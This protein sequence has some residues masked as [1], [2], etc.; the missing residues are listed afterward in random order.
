[1]DLQKLRL[2]AI[3]DVKKKLKE[4]VKQDWLIIQASA[5]LDEL[6][7]A[8]N[9]LV[10]RLREWYELY[11]PEFSNAMRDHERFVSMILTRTKEDLLKEIKAKETMGAELKKVDIDP[12]L[13]LAKEIESL[14]KLNKEQEKYLETLMKKECPNTTAIAG[15]L[16]GAKLIVLAGSLERLSKFPAST[17]QVLGAE[18]ALFRHLKN[19]NNKPPKYGILHEHAFISKVAGKNRGK[20]ARALADKIAIASKVDLFKGKYVGDMLMEQL[21]KRA[22]AL[23]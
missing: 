23:R 13:N 21:N 8:S 11:N 16:I 20:M 22:K 3:E 6:D 12:I 14:Y 4:A 18:T 7:K 19:R 15:V 10:K 2:K 5:G 9:L 17:V 1:M